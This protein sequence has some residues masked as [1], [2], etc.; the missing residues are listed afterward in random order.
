[1]RFF[2]N[3]RRRRTEASAVEVLLLASVGEDVLER[4]AL[5]E[6]ERGADLLDLEHDVLVVG[7][8]VLEGSKDVASLVVAALLDEPAGR[9]IERAWE[10]ASAKGTVKGRVTHSGIDMTVQK[11]MIAKMIWNAT[12]RKGG[13]GVRREL[14]RRQKTGGDSLGT[15]HDA[16]ATR[17]HSEGVRVSRLRPKMEAVRGDAPRRAQSRRRG[18]CRTRTQRRP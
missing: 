8:D 6:R 1:V 11:M 15:R 12:T 3:R 2:P 7:A 5:D 17:D 4:A 14:S 16:Y 18:R 9:P 13:R 10:S